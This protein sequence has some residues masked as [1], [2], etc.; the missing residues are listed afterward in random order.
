MKLTIKWLLKL[1]LNTFSTSNIL[2]FLFQF[3][4]YFKWFFTFPPVKSRA[5][6]E[7]S[8]VLCD[9]P[10]HYVNRGEHHWHAGTRN[11]KHKYC[12]Q[13]KYYK[14]N[15]QLKLKDLLFGSYLC[16]V[17]FVF[18]IYR[19]RRLGLYIEREF[20]HLHVVTKYINQISHIHY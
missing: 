11:E 18:W 5:S 13:Y 4:I 17:M 10:P 1:L 7:V 3:S 9:Q 16:F 2:H 15:D 19:R 20:L 14:T 12:K 6:V 8:S